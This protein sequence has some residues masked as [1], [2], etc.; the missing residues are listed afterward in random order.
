M[1]TIYKLNGSNGLSYIGRTNNLK[2]R[3]YEHRN[4][5]H[6]NTQS[7][8]LNGDFEVEILEECEGLDNKELSI[9]ERY[10]I[11]NNICVNK[12]IPSRDKNEYK[13]EY[14]K[15]D[16]NL[17]KFK[18]VQKRHYEK[19]GKDR[20]IRTKTLCSCGSSYPSR[21]K[22][23]HFLTKKHIAYMYNADTHTSETSDEKSSG[24]EST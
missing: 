22:K 4:P 11:D 12:V 1:I 6:N 5:K 24:E 10:Y 7:K 15:N 21:N 16:E 18:I 2:R 14:L 3:L 20:N 23:A 17:K 19:F 8:L 9:K 13:R